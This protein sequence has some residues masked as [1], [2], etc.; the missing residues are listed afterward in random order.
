MDNHDIWKSI[1]VNPLVGRLVISAAVHQAKAQLK[2]T[3]WQ[4]VPTTLRDQIDHVIHNVQ[5]S[6]VINPQGNGAVDWGRVL[7][8]F[9]AKMLARRPALHRVP[10][11]FPG[12]IGVV[13][14]KSQSAVRHRVMAVIDTSA[15]MTGC[16]LERIGGELSQLAREC[17]IT[18]VQCDCE[19]RAIHTFRGEITEVRG[20]GNTDLRPPFEPAI[21]GQVRPDLIIYFTDGDGPAPLKPPAI[22]TIWCLNSDVRPA[23]WG[24]P[25]MIGGFCDTT[26]GRN[27]TDDK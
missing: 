10:R 22:P 25:I 14:G 9:I 16:M 11:R 20:R 21:I 23:P 8:Q 27:E 18:V 19:V 24:L 5:S 4:N 7:R 26:G 13:P 15:S 3:D 17:D 12:M 2:P 1:R 6:E